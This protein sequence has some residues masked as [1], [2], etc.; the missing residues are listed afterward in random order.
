MTG[1]MMIFTRGPY[2]NT[3][4]NSGARRPS[5]LRCFAGRLE[6]RDLSASG[7]HLATATSASVDASLAEF[8]VV[9]LRTGLCVDGHASGL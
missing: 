9:Q 6:A 1:E 2:L 8:D 4:F 7:L 5:S 3:P